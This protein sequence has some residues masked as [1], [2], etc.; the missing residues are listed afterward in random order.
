MCFPRL[1]M[2]RPGVRQGRGNA[3]ASRRVSQDGARNQAALLLAALQDD[4]PPRRHSHC[5]WRGHMVRN[6]LIFQ[7]NRNCF[8]KQ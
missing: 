2:P 7:S 1:L 3:L 5:D 4:P 6:H 8:L